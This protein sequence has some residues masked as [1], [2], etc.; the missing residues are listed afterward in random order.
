MVH[1]RKSEKNEKSIRRIRK[2]LKV[3][4]GVGYKMEN[5]SPKAKSVTVMLVIPPVL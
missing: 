3:V 1:V 2:Y 4:W 5:S